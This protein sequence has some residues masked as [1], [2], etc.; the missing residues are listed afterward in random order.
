M[1]TVERTGRA[2]SLSRLDRIKDLYQCFIVVARLGKAADGTALRLT[3]TAAPSRTP[4]HILCS[5][6]VR[7]TSQ[8]KSG[9]MRRILIPVAAQR[10][11]VGAAGCTAS[12]PAG[13]GK[14]A[15]SAASQT[16]TVDMPS[17]VETL[18]PA[19]TIDNASWKITYPTYEHLVGYK[20]ASTDIQPE[21]AKSWTSS[22]R[23]QGMDVQARQRAHL[24]RRLTGQRRGGQVQLRPSAEDQ[25]GSR[26]QLRGGRQRRGSRPDDGAVHPEEP[27]APFPSTL[28][29]NYASIINP[30]VMEHQT[31]GDQ[32]QAYLANHTMGSGPYELVSH[33]KGQS[34]TLGLNP[35]YAGPKPSIT[36]AVFQIVSDSSAQRL[37]L[38]KGDVDVAEGITV[39]QIKPLESTEGVTVVKKPS[40]WSTTST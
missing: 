36:K 34:L 23:R 37:Q 1:P 38:E 39:D 11:L 28:A 24:L 6:A 26:R 30:K 8:R 10:L 20:G 35:H 17:D 9:H 21:L 14:G 29:T 2:P 33:V 4:A 19:V 7:R 16:L 40:F 31:N 25:P 22:E 32:G 27:F 12:N 13:A 18:D 5:G 3:P 15:A